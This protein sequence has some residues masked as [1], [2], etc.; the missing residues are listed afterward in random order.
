M[1]NDLL[2]TDGIL[3]RLETERALL[4]ERVEKIPAHL[5]DSRPDSTSW[6]IAEVLEHVARVETGITKLLTVRGQEP[7]PSET[8]DP[9]QSSIYDSRLQGLVRDRGKRIEAPERV[10]P[11]GAMS[12]SDGLAHL[13]TTRAGL[14]SAFS[15]AN[16]DALDKMTHPHT[17]FGPLTLRSWMALVADHDA[18]HADQIDD[19][20]DRLKTS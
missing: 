18:R 6:S 1:S 5:R 20:A 13:A 3:E 10:H 8:P 12:A 19:I 15:S 2:S 7:P 9:E 16:S 4:V 11:T 17:V 14:L